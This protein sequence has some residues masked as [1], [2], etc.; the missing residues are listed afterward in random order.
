ML[1][2]TWDST[3][4][5]ISTRFTPLITS[6]GRTEEK[7]T[8]R[9]WNTPGAIVIVGVS[10]TRRT[11][12][13]RPYPSAVERMALVTCINNAPFER[14]ETA[15]GQSIS[16]NVYSYFSPPDLCQA[17]NMNTNILHLNLQAFGVRTPSRISPLQVVPI[18][19]PNCVLSLK[20]HLPCILSPRVIL[21]GSSH[22]LLSHV[23]GK[24]RWFGICYSAVSHNGHVISSAGPINKSHYCLLFTNI[25]EPR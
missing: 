4:R 13:P 9:I 1:C 7:S 19:T 2:G 20:L 21:S 18:T 16:S 17:H 15:P 6:I 25:F 23:I 22:K 5:R 11:K 3:I 12:R 14:S 24:W 8:T 10:P